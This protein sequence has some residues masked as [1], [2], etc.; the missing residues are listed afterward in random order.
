[1]NLSGK[2]VVIT[3]GAGIL[4]QAVAATLGGYGAKLALIDHAKIP[5]AGQPGIALHY[6]SIDGWMG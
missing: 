3:G 1:M 4:G 5:P 6:G 2:V